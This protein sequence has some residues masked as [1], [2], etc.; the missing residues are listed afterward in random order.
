MGRW[1]VFRTFLNLAHGC[2]QEPVT[3]PTDLA[4]IAIFCTEH[5][6]E[7]L[8]VPIVSKWVQAAWSS[9]LVDLDLAEYSDDWDWAVI[10]HEFGLA[11]IFHEAC[12]RLAFLV[13]LNPEDDNEEKYS[14]TK[15]ASELHGAS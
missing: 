8:A 11:E 14:S 6:L 3:S 5:Q 9:R 4:D 1:K 7:A 12:Y 15:F 2:H 10:G 13:D